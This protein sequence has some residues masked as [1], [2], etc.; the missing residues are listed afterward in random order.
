M[1]GVV[2]EILTFFGILLT[3]FVV[4]CDILKNVSRGTFILKL[5]SKGKNDETK[6]EY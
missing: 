1:R 5:L 4:L 6:K 2:L 3:F